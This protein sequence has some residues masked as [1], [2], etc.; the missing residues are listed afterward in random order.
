[1]SRQPRFRRWCSRGGPF[2]PR[3]SASN[4]HLDQK[5]ELQRLGRH[6]MF[7]STRV[8]EK[9]PKDRHAPSA[10]TDGLSPDEAADVLRLTARH[11]SGS[12]EIKAG[13]DLFSLG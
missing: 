3:D 5:Y 9:V 7:D 1:M 2:S 12:R 13:S 6:K 10:R 8:S 11:K 4:P